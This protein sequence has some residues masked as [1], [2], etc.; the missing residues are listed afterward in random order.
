MNSI[1]PKRWLDERPGRWIAETHWPSDIIKPL[2]LYLIGED[3][4]SDKPGSSNATVSSPQDCGACAGEYFP[5]AFSDEL[6]D[7]QSYDDARS[8]CF[9]SDAMIRVSTSWEHRLSL[10]RSH[11]ARPMH[12]LPSGYWINGQT[13]HRRLSPMEYTTL[14][15]VLRMNFLPH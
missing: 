14:P 7:E 5:F 12:R 1:K 13:E 2:E 15:T 10:Y 3:Q 6:P 11:R 8:C 4:L 9:Y